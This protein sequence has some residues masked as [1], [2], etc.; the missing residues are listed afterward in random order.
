VM[1]PD[2]ARSLR[3]QCATAGVPFFCKQMTRGWIPPDLQI[4]EFPTWP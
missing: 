3:D 4:W 2:W 1:D